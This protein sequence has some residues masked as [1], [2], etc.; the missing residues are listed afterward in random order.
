MRV[1]VTG[2]AGFAGRHVAATLAAAGHEVHG[3]ALGPAAVPGAAVV[4]AADLLD[5]TGLA[6]VVAAAAPE[7]VVHLAAVSFVPAAEADPRLAVRVNVE[8]TVGL[9]EALDAGAPRARLLLVGSADAYGC[10]SPEEVPIHETVPLRPLSVYGATKAAAETVALQWARRHG[11]DVVVARPFNH[12]GPGQAPEFVVPAFARQIARI[13][14]GLEEPVVRV[15]DLDPVRDVSDVRDVARGY[16]ALLERGARGEVY[17]LCAGRGVAIRE[18]LERL[19]AAAGVDVRVERDPARG[20]PMEVPR[21]V[22]S[23]ARATEATAWR[24][25]IPLVT[26]L[27]DVLDDWRRRETS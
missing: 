6:R 23:H 10:V 17:N 1:L 11:R 26:T 2:I 22:G 20:R 7:A 27:T 19:L 16:L 9:L 15:G 13:A 12:T 24:P 18:I 3:L 4:H 21:I 8:G 14:A 5:Q 25:E